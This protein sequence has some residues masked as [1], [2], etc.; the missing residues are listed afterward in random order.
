MSKSN[1]MHDPKS[2]LLS[3][4]QQAV[5][6]AQPAVCVPKFLPQAPP[7]RTFVVGAGKASAA[8]AQAVERHWEGALSGLVITRYGFGV[9]C[10]QIEIVEASHPIPDKAGATATERILEIAAAATEEDLL[11]V[12]I[13]GGGSALMTLPA[14]G[15]TLAEKQQSNEALLASGAPI[16]AMN[17]IRK[18]LSKIKGGRLA[19]AAG[20][21]T[22]HTLVI[23][24]VV[25]DDPATIA[26]GPTVPDPT[27]Y[28]DARHYVEEFEIALPDAAIDCLQAEHDESPKLGHPAFAKATTEIVAAPSAS[29][30]EAAELA[31][32]EGYRVI[33]LGDAVE[34]EAR[35]VGRAHANLALDVD[36]GTVILSGGELTVTLDRKGRGGPNAEYALALAE[37]LGSGRPIYALAA[38]TDG[39]DGSEDNAGAIVD[40]DTLLRAHKT[41]L[42]PANFLANHNSY[43]FFAALDDLVMT[44]PTQTN[45]NDF[46]AI[47]VAG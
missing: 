15:L 45:V 29:L 34:G 22:V 17:C 16:E 9:P 11:L 23:S 47:L 20:D 14:E 5:T 8:M 19:A 6:V 42:D 31:E 7:G 32:N 30:K 33:S 26:S 46:R 41:G 18:H 21:T 39:I 1:S 10:E 44:G 25:G 13:S 36:P 3:M 37:A 40:P 2:S 35:E 4:F 28:A 27:T 24:D 12:L 43:E 38:D